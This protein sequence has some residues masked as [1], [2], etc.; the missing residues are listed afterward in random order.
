MSTLAGQWPKIS[1]PPKNAS[2]MI[3]EIARDTQM[4]HESIPN[5]LNGMQVKGGS[6]NW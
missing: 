4:L 3:T 2:E 5:E 1:E 6:T